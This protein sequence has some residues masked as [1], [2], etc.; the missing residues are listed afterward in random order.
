MTILLETEFGIGDMV[1]S[2]LDGEYT[3]IVNSYCI[4]NVDKTGTVVVYNLDC[5]NPE[6]ALRCFRP[7]EVEIV[8]KVNI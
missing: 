3:Y 6:G 5:G 2:K 8:E 1:K 4:I 7:Y